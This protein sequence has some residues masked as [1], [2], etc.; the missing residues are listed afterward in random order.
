MPL[1]C[2]GMP[3]VLVCCLLHV[4]MLVL[5]LLVLR[6]VLCYVFMCRMLL[7]LFPCCHE[8]DVVDICA[9]D[10]VVVV[11]T[12]SI[13]V[14]LLLPLVVFFMVSMMLMQLNVWCGNVIL[15]SGVVVRCVVVRVGCVF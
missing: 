13:I 4:S 3:R 10:G 14:L 6:V 7:V 15:N 9:I 1:M 11:V 2:S 5:V 8:G 12:T